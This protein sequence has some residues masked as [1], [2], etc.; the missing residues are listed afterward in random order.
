LSLEEV[1]ALEITK[2]VEQEALPLAVAV[3]SQMLVE[4][5]VDRPLLVV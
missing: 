3:V 2:W 1:V 5:W 4:D